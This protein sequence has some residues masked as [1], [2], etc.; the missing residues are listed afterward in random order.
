MTKMRKSLQLT[1]VTTYGVAVNSHSNIVSNE[2]RL[3][4]LFAPEG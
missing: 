1:L 3:D 4:D 2:V